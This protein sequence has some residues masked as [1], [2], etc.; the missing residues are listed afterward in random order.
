M[1]LSKRCEPLTKRVVLIT[2]SAVALA[3]GVGRRRLVEFRQIGGPY[4][5]ILLSSN[6]V[7]DSARS[8]Y[9]N[10]LK[11]MGDMA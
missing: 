11:A 4:P 10:G 3:D 5:K 1:W 8:P 9:M 7:Y 2:G 6:I